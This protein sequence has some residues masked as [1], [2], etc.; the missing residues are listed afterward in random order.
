MMVMFLSAPRS[1][2]TVCCHYGRILMPWV[3]GCRWICEFAKGRSNH[4]PFIA[5]VYAEANIQ[6]SYIQRFPFPNVFAYLLPLLRVHGLFPKLTSDVGMLTLSHSV[7]ETIML[8][9]SICCIEGPGDSDQ[10]ANKVFSFSI[11]N[12]HHLLMF[13]AVTGG[14]VDFL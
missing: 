10:Q 8:I 2:E 9:S 5:V 7:F 6:I 3:W 4:K 12:F 11:A 1:C 13:I 14:V